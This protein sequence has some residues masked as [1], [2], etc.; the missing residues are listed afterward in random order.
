M[1][2][3][4]YITKVIKMKNLKYLLGTLILTL[5]FS[6]AFAQTTDDALKKLFDLSKAKNYKE[7]AALIAY[8]GKE[9]ARKLKDTY[10]ADD[11]KE[12]NKV[13]RVCKKIKA[14]LDI[15]DSYKLGNVTTKKDQDVEWTI[16]QVEFKSGKQTLKTDFAFVKLN[17]NFVL[18]DID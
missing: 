7:A 2:T 14:L 11:K 18:G 10:K 9:A 8:D 12:L 16:H 1:F 5:T 15:S 6:N 4:T 13:K 17:G 3:K